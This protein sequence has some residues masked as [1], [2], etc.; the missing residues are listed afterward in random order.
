MKS[1][2]DLMIEAERA[3]DSY[4]TA[5]RSAASA[6][7]DYELAYYRALAQSVGTSAAARKEEAERAANDQ[8]RAFIIAEAVEKAA[9]THVQVTLGLMVAE[10]SRQK[11]AGQQDGGVDF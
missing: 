8:H 11:F 4:G 10:Q 9:K 7:A 6:R 5:V 2:A 1:L 3:D